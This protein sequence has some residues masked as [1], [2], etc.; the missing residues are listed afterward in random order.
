MTATNELLMLTDGQAQLMGDGIVM[1]FQDSD[2]G[3]QNV[4][5]TRADLEALLAAC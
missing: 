5:L 1:V 2:G 4:I 3:V